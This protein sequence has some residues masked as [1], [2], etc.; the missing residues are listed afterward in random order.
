MAAATSA[1][2][3]AAIR[4]V[5]GQGVRGAVRSVVM[6]V[7]KLRWRAKRGHPGS[8]GHRMGHLRV[9]AVACGAAG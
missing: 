3:V 4:A 9:V 8:L 6:R 1:A 5:G 7:G 2:R